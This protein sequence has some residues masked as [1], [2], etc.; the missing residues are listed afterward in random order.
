MGHTSSGYGEPSN[1][2][3]LYGRVDAATT[4]RGVRRNCMYGVYEHDGRRSR[5]HARSQAPGDDEHKQHDC[6]FQCVERES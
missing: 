4:R 6:V 1:A 5:E 3:P 2:F